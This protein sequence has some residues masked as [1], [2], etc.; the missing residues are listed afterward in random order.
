MNNQGTFLIHDDTIDHAI[1]A[2]DYRFTTKEAA[3]RAAKKK[4][5]QQRRDYY[6]SEIIVGIELTP[7]IELVVVEDQKLLG[8][9]D[10]RV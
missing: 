6:V 2:T 1:W 3:L 8:N 7:D 5:F 9:D 4:A 10:D